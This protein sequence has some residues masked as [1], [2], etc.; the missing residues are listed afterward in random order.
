MIGGAVVGAV[1]GSAALV[2]SMFFYSSF[3]LLSLAVSAHGVSKVS[4]QHPEKNKKKSS[5]SHAKSQP[6]DSQLK[7][8]V[9]RIIGNDMP[10]LQRI[11]QLRWNTEY[12][13]K[14]E[15]HPSFV[16]V[17]WILNHILDKKEEGGLLKLL[18][19]HGQNFIHLKLDA[20][21]LKCFH[22]R[23]VDEAALY[24]SNQ[25][26]ARNRALE[27]GVK[28]KANWVFVLDG[29]QFLVNDFWKSMGSIIKQAKG[30]NFRFREILLPMARLMFA[31]NNKTVNSATNYSIGVPQ[32]F[33]SDHVLIS[34]PQL[35][36]HSTSTLRFNTNLTYGH[37]NK[38]EMLERICQQKKPGHCCGFSSF[39]QLVHH[40][41]EVSF[42][43]SPA[44]G[45]KGIFDVASS[46][47]LT[48]R[49]YSF[50]ESTP[51]NID[52]VYKKNHGLLDLRVHLRR[53]SF[54]RILSKIA[55]VAKN[56]KGTSVSC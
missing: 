11:G 8:N 27:E 51:K 33:P 43:K 46:C 55:V 52:A 17:T 26:V 6:A 18:T 5:K 24:L 44:K 53:E 31:E 35:A 7:V 22:G 54:K 56:A 48:I 25:N 2:G 19:D 47:G 38:V 41:G 42:P 4:D 39:D 20:M 12:A 45:K 30:P 37:K 10:P 50:P 34:E 28:N 15:R 40:G 32:L 36:F 3:L 1:V 23:S 29:N 49:L 21:K 16:H 9:Y 13:L 14:Y